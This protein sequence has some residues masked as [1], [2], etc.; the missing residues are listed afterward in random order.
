DGIRYDLVTGVQTCALPISTTGSLVVTPRTN[1]YGQVTITVTVSD[2][3][4]QNGSISRSFTVTIL[5]V[6]DGP[7]L[8]PIA[9]VSFPGDTPIRSEE[10]RVGEESSKR[11]AE[12]A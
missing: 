7:T 8:N 3:Q 9:N 1:A 12:L 11:R 2:G 10:R 6:N 4:S 5:P